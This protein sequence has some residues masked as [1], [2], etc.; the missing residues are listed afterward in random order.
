MI[1]RRIVPAFTI[2][3]ALAALLTWFVSRR[4]SRP[5]LAAAPAPMDHLAAA[6]RALNV[7]DTLTPDALKLVPWPAAALPAASMRRTQD[8]MGRVLL[9]PVAAGEP[10]LA[11]YLAAPGTGAGL[12]ARI[13]DGMRAVSVHADEISGVAGFVNPDS[14]VDIVATTHVTGDGHASTACILQDVRVLAVGQKLDAEPAGKPSPTGDT[15]T[16]LLSNADA[17]T[18][19]QATAI[20]KILLLLRNGADRAAVTVGSI[21]TP[22]PMPR[23]EQIAAR[24]A[25]VRSVAA[26]PRS[27]AFV[28]ETVAGSKESSESFEGKN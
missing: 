22:T 16:L 8:A 2:A 27:T 3:L 13:P 18:L 14:F 6:A 19:A 25:V 15:I 10:V 28:V 23:L 26:L 12:P 11:Q 1:A 4:V 9:V 7:G 24:P 17:Q 21:E 20:G 5:V